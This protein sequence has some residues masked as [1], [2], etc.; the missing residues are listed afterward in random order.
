M[1]GH[2]ADVE[3]CRFHPNSNYIASGGADRELAITFKGGPQPEFFADGI[4]IK[5]YQTTK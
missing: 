4:R 3:V 1:S 5:T 2:H